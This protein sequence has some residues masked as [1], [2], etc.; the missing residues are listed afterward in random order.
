[1]W[2]AALRLKGSWPEVGRRRHYDK[3]K[4]E[5]IKTNNVKQDIARIFQLSA[6]LGSSSGCGIP[7]DSPKYY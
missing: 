2:A 7:E 1:M 6:I 4:R 5:N 3:R